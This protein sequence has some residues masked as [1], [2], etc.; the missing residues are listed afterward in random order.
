MGKPGRSDLI[1]WIALPFHLAI[2]ISLFW[3]VHNGEFGSSFWIWIGKWVD[4]PTAVFTYMI[5]I[6]TSILAAYTFR[7]WAS[8]TEQASQTQQMYILDKRAFIHAIALNP[9]PE[10]DAGGAHYNWRF[11]PVLRNGS[12]THADS[13]EMC[14]EC[15]VRNIPLPA[16]HDYDNLSAPIGSGFFGPKTD[17]QGGIA[18]PM[19]IAAITPDDILSAQKDQKFIYV[20]GWIKYYD[21]FTPYFQHETHYCWQ[22]SPV[23][24]PLDF[25]ATDFD[26]SSGRP[27]PIRFDTLHHTYG[28]YIR[29]TRMNPA[30]GLP[31]FDI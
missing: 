2:P 6:V 23:G 18:P 16:H 29:H 11:R 26:G 7:L 5:Y 27:S 25:T 28:N 3:Y 24:N 1:A 20:I 17:L 31:W 10:L 8:A 15:V 12:E 4:D 13:V 30:T 19:Q 9:Y 21:I 14:F 22:V